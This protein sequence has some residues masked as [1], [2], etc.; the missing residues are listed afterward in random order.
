MAVV[1][2]RVRA[3]C[4][5]LNADGL[6][7]L[8]SS[9]VA[10]LG[11]K[12]GEHANLAVFDRR[13]VI[14]LCK[15]D[16]EGPERLF[17][18]LGAPRPA[19]CTALGKAILAYQEP[20]ITDAYLASAELRPLTPRPLRALLSFARS[21]AKSASRALPRMMRSI[22]MA[23]AALQSRFLTLPTAWWPRWACSVLRGGFQCHALQPREPSSPDSDSDCHVSSDTGALIPDWILGDA[24]L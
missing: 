19:Y 15:F 21:F 16:G 23:Y 7:R 18:R 8:G 17:E 11:Q 13:H 5:C 4:G 6:A 12:T 20:S 9:T 14:V 1:W 2:S 10:E 22:R 3:C 24:F